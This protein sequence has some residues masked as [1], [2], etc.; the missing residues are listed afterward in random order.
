MRGL[1]V[2]AAVAGSAGF[3]ITPKTTEA[4]IRYVDPNG[5]PAPYT[6]RTT[7]RPYFIPAMAAAAGLT[8]VGMIEAI[9][10]ARRSQRDASIVN[11]SGASG[12]APSGSAST[13]SIR[14]VFTVDGRAGMRLHARF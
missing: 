4:E 3:A 14:P 1:I 6:E 2:L 10:Y 5:A 12:V 7:E 9:V 8:V 13:F 11:R